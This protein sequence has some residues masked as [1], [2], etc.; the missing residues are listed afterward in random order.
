MTIHM[1]CAARQ[2]SVDK[3]GLF[4]SGIVTERKDGEMSVASCLINHK[5][6]IRADYVETGTIKLLNDLTTI[7]RLLYQQISSLVLDSRVETAVPQEN[8]TAASAV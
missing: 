7:L 3:I 1:V 6:N 8:L 2:D 4:N 5:S